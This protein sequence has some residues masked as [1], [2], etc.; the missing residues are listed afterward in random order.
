MRV[1]QVVRV[2][3]SPERSKVISTGPVINYQGTSRNRTASNNFD[4]EE[5]DVDVP[6]VKGDS[7]AVIATQVR[8]MYNAGSGPSIMFDPPLAEGDAFRTTSLDSGFLMLQAE[9]APP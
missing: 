7:L 8:F 9:L 1:L 5:F 4:I 2:R 6:I 3:Q